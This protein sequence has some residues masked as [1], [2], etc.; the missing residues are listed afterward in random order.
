MDWVGLGFCCFLS[1]AAWVVSA[2]VASAMV[3]AGFLFVRF[4][5]SHV[6][7]R[8][9]EELLDQFLTFTDSLLQTAFH[10]MKK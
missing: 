10:R 5:C 4:F 9:R 6:D 7:V 1:E 2:H 3:L 8:P